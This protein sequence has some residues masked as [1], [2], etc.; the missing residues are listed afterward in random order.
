MS[1]KIT[2]TEAVK[3]AMKAKDMAQVKVLRGVQAAI[4]QIEIDNQV[5][6]DDKGVLEIIQKQLKQR[7]ESLEIYKTNGR[8]D[9]AEQEQFEINVISQFLPEQLSEDAL[10]A[11]ITET[12]SDLGASGM[13]DM[14][15][16]MNAVKDKT[17]GQADPA[18]V[19]GLVKKAL[20]G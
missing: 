14:G 19:S 1:L 11:I 17:T 12:I 18:A 10:N 16:V 8:D 9:L 7:S 15:R 20:A 13:K 3:T 2:L 4:K 6:L 5:E